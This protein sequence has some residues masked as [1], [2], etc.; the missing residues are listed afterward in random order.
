VPILMIKKMAIRE[1]K[2]L[3]CNFKETKWLADLA[4]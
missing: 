2:V 3:G 1:P 4:G